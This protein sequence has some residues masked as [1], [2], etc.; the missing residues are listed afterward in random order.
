MKEGITDDDRRELL[1]LLPGD[2]VV[3]TADWIEA[4]AKKMRE[5]G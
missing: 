1:G 5:R 4:L 2:W 3:R